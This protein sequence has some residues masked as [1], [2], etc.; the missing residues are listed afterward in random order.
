PWAINGT[1]TGTGST[2]SLR[3]S[4]DEGEFEQGE[5][6]QFTFSLVRV[7]TG[8]EAGSFSAELVVA[9]PC[10]PSGIPGTWTRMLYSTGQNGVP[11]KDGP[12]LAGEETWI[13]TADR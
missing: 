4:A 6:V 9:G 7:S 12:M 2:L 5:R 3:F 1:I 10:D 13:L 8:E 11:H